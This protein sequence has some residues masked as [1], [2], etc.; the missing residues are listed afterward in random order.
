MLTIPK[1][2][3]SESYKE[4]IKRPG[5]IEKPVRKE[6]VQMGLCCSSAVVSSRVRG[7]PL[8]FPA[9]L[10]QQCSIDFLGGELRGMKKTH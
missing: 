6:L 4:Q 9:N 1:V 3:T 2:P 7:K 10:L 8:L 5:M